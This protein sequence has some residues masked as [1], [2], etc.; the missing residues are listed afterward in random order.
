MKYLVIIRLFSKTN[1]LMVSKLVIGTQIKQL[2]LQGVHL[3]ECGGQYDKYWYKQRQWVITF[4][5]ILS[6]FLTIIINKKL[7]ELII[8]MNGSGCQDEFCQKI[9]HWIVLS[10]F[11]KKLQ[12]FQFWELLIWPKSWNMKF[13]LQR[14]GKK[15]LQKDVEYLIFIILIIEGVAY[16]HNTDQKRTNGKL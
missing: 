11:F 2:T 1:I 13:Q 12:N 15:Q 7:L 8:K 6:V 14:L 3:I 10:D 16:F 5:Q 4:E 9:G